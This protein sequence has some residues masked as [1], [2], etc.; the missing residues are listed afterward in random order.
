M[1]MFHPDTSCSR[2]ARVCEQWWETS[3]TQL[4]PS[5]GCWW[6][7]SATQVFPS[8]GCWWETSATQLF[9]SSGC[10]TVACLLYTRDTLSDDSHFSGHTIPSVGSPEQAELSVLN[11]ISA[12]AVLVPIFNGS[13][14]F[15][16]V[17]IHIWKRTQ[18]FSIIC[19]IDPKWGLYPTD[20]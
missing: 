10:C 9:P 17:S 8:N 2:D 16:T 18:R 14:D 7:T 13:T 20:A 1:A 4:F 15:W 11:L 6:E 3:A 12:R 19:R 5:S